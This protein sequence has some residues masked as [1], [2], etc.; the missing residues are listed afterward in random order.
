[1]NALQSSPGGLSQSFVIGLFGK[2]LDLPPPSIIAGRLRLSGLVFPLTGPVRVL[3]HGHDSNSSAPVYRVTA[4]V[5]GNVLIQTG[6]DL[7]GM[8]RLILV[9][10]WI[11]H[12][13]DADPSD[14]SPESDLATRALR[15]VVR[16]RQPFGALLLT[17]LGRRSYRRVA[18]DSFIKTQ[19]QQEAMLEGLMDSIRTVDIK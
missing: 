5:L 12:L 14:D 2:L 16:L 3:N 15:L 7:S 17:S 6:D 18:T 9:H 19:V 11:T 8:Q 4:P 10:P 13:L 1:M